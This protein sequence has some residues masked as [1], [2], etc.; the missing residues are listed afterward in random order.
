MSIIKIKTADAVAPSCAD[1]WR[2]PFGEKNNILS[3]VRAYGQLTKPGIVMGNLVST[4]GGFFLAAHWAM[5]PVLLLA[6]VLG[7][8]LVVASGCV[9]NNVID[10]DIDAKMRRTRNRVLVRGAVTPLAALGFGC[11]LGVAGIATLAVAVNP[12]SAWLGVAGLAVYVGLYT[13]YMKR[14]STLGTL[15]GS[16]SGAMPPVIGY[17][18]VTGHFDACAALLLVIFCLW[19]MPHSY[20]IAI[21][22]LDDYTAANIAVLP[23]RAGVAV[24]KRH[25]VLYLFAFVAAAMSLP[26][27]GYAGRLYA[28]VVGAV[29]LYWVYVA[30]AGYSD[31]D[32]KAWARRMFIC[33]IIAVM[34]ISLMMLVNF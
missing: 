28:V 29:C 7:V 10:R 11:F 13:L 2:M 23:V 9:F 22:H 20:A 27:F 17:C 3:A 1:Q 32:V 18:A 25:A 8:A 5:N 4:V 19:Q 6:A 30:L 26:L 12:L 34:A 24:T 14:H 15:V 33:S 31:A 21:F 16:L